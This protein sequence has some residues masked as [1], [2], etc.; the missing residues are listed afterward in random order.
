M[1]ALVAA[2]R[3]VLAAVGRAGELPLVTAERAGAPPELAAWLRERGFIGSYVADVLA[4]ADRIDDPAGALLEELV[5]LSAGWS[6]CR[7]SVSCAGASF[8]ARA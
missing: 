7:E 2:N 6:S 1:Q 3:G 5:E 4:V 8:F